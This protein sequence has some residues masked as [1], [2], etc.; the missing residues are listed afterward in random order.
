MAYTFDP[1][2]ANAP[3]KRDT[4]YFEIG[5][6]RAIYHD[7]WIAATAC[8]NRAVGEPEWKKRMGKSSRFPS[9]SPWWPARK[10][11]AA[12]AFPC[13]RNGLTSE[14]RRSSI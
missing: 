6:N 7:D 3:S 10:G 14:M 9:I 13:A 5:G 8:W 4:Q 1:A 2:S 11:F 12:R